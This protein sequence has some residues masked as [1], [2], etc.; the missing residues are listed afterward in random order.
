MAATAIAVMVVATAVS[1]LA[2]YYNSSKARGA[3]KEEL[4]EIK[5]LFTELTPP[6]YD[7]D[8]TD[9]PYLHTEK[10]QM[11]EFSTPD[12]KPKWD[13]SK[14]EPNSIS[15]MEKY[16]PEI[17]PR[18]IESNPTLIEKSQD[19]KLGADAQKTAMRRFMNIGEGGFDPAYQ[20]RVQNAKR[21]AQGEAQSR[22]DSIMQ[23]FQRRG[24]GGSG[25]ELAAK[26]GGASQSMDRNAQMG[27][28]AEADAYRNQLNS[29]SRGSD[30]GGQI[31][32][33]DIGVQSKNAQI[34]N[35]FNQRMSKRHQDWA[36]MRANAMN[37][38]D[39]RNIQEAQRISEHNANTQNQ[40]DQ[41]H[42]TRMDGIAMKNYQAK[43]DE[44]NRQDS[45]KKWKYGQEGTERAN[46]NNANILRSKWKQGEKR[47]G[48]E[49][50]GKAYDDE[51]R[52]RGGIA[53]SQSKIADAGMSD[54][55]DQNAAIQGMSN[56]ATA[57]GM[58]EEEENRKDKR[59]EKYGV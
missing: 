29:L 9:P 21:Q 46:L 3:R 5:K 14:L 7:L 34:I 54:A 36:N 30:I 1:T 58:Q 10:L 2:Q 33:R 27:M 25:M 39:L 40:Y 17:A 19:M 55:R 16:I 20:Q 50:K 44:L 23:D 48:N 18:I 59:A 28:Q 22:S 13:L 24:M 47:Y 31:Q 32:D 4:N 11:P 45:L 43:I 42:Q 57:W 53:G 41:G 52:R 51:L 6:D 37:Q 15:L 12:G 26:M 8:I 49:M 38:A 56:M 35:S